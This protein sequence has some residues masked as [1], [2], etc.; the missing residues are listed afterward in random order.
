MTKKLCFKELISKV[1]HTQR[2]IHNPHCEE[3]I[4]HLLQLHPVW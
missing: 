1:S 2:D 4:V 3:A